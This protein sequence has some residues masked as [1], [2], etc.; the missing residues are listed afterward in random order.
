MT[1]AE[2]KALPLTAAKM[3]RHV[4]SS[5]AFVPMDCANYLV[6]VAL[7]GADRK[8]DLARLRA[9]RVPG[10]T[11]INYDPTP[12]TIRSRRSSA[13]AASPSSPSSTEPP[14]TR[15]GP[16]CL[17]WSWSTRSRR[18]QTGFSFVTDEGSISAR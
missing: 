18:F 14:A 15:N 13:P 2:P 7:K 4:H 6:M 5:Q 1:T 8:P 12:G 3:E 11:G 16:T 9:F 17:S 10:D